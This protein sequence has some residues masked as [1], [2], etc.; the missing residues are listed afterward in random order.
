MSI[1]GGLSEGLLLKAMWQFLTGTLCVIMVRTDSSSR[2]QWLQRTGVGRLKH[3]SARLLWTQDLIQRRLVAIGPVTTK[4]NVS[5]LNT[6]KLSVNRRNFLLFFLQAVE[7]DDQFEVVKRIGAQESLEYSGSLQAAK[8][9]KAIVKTKANRGLVKFLMLCQ[10]LTLQ[11]C[12]NL[13]VGEV[14]YVCLESFIF[15]GM[16]LLLLAIL[17]LQRRIGSLNSGGAD[18]EMRE[19]WNLECEKCDMEARV[20]EM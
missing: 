12:Q 6:K 20:R 5:D 11:G 14:R 9:M 13:I 18:C 3:Y 8:C 19:M 15:L 4:L 2:R 16:V 10:A 7:V 17:C 1:T